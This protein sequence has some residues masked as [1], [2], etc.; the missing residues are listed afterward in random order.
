MRALS[1]RKTVEKDFFEVARFVLD[2]MFGI[3]RV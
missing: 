1:V 2:C 3:Q